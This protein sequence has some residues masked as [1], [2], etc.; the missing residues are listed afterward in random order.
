MPEL[1]EVETIRRGLEKNL[2]GKTISNL[3]VLSPK[4]F[5]GDPKLV[6]GK[7]IIS[8]SR[9]GKQLSIY[10]SGNYLLLIHLKMTGQLIF[11]P[12]FSKGVRGILF[13]NKYTRLVI[14]FIDKSNLYFNDLRKFGWIRLIK[15]NELPSLQ[16]NI[17]VDLLDKKFTLKYFSSV[18]KN[19]KK[20]I[21]TV[22]LDQS[23]FTG[24]GNIYANESLFLAKIY[25]LKPANEIS[26]LKTK[27][28]YLA[29]LKVIKE[30]IKHGGS[31]AKDKGY[32]QSSG[33]AGTHQN[34]FQVY[35]REG[36]PC[37]ICHT[38]IKRIKTSG[39]S[40]FF[41][42]HCQKSN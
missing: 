33:E 17:G 42:P 36:K 40:T 4:S 21:K 19:S 14:S 35:Q 5:I 32:L 18:L 41:C 13:P 2:V 12:P 1:P 3:E 22:L 28:L 29:I 34:Y 37:F 10:L 23:H 8:V 24:I 15:T 6:K 11:V 16:K 20:P 9:L 25:P 7:K 39:R 31:T 26:P 38:P 27:N 30:S